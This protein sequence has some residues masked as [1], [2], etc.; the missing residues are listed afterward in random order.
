MGGRAVARD[1]TSRP[2][3]AVLLVHH[4]R[5]FNA[6]AGDMDS[7]RGGGALVGV[8]R[9]VSTLFQMTAE[10]AAVYDIKEEERHH[11]LRFDDAKANLTLVTFAARW[12]YKATV[13][14]PNAGDDGEPAD[15]IGVL[16]P[17]VPQGI[18]AR[19]TPDVAN[20]ILDLITKGIAVKEDKPNDPFCLSRRGGD[21]KRWAGNV[22]MGAVEC[23]RDEAQKVLDT[24][25]E[26]GLLVEYEIA[27]TTSKGRLR[28]GLRVVD[29]HRPGTLV[30]RDTL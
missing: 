20:A 19:L 12:F 24:W 3:A 27:T 9:I 26:S 6:E 23:T 5:K 14:L 7:A 25:V 10:E 15:E 4:T 11:Y 28:K 1:R 8:A 22:I 18:F 13:T 29:G 16:M 30:S 17:W 2:I 21:N